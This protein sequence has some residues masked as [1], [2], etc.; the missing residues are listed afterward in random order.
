M[1][2][3]DL[4]ILCQKIKYNPSVSQLEMDINLQYGQRIDYKI[5]F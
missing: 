5:E 2:L 1:N 4:N 3:P